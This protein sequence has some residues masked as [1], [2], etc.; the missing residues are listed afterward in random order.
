MLQQLSLPS[1]KVLWLFDFFVNR[2][3]LQIRVV[4]LQ[5]QSFGSVL[6][7]FGRDV[8][9]HSRHA[10]CLLLR[11]FQNHLLTSFFILLCHFLQLFFRQKSFSNQV[12]K[13]HIFFYLQPFSTFFIE[14][15]ISKYKLDS[16]KLTIKTAQIWTISEIKLQNFRKKSCPKMTSCNLFYCW[17]F[18]EYW[19]SN[20]RYFCKNSLKSGSSRACPR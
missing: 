18:N 3:F 14:N 9:R 17:I 16:Q 12:A 8:S 1:L 15:K 7:V 13:I 11:A 19:C 6:A 4:L 20:S 2:H 5:L 10:A